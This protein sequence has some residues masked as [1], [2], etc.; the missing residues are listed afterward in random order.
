MNIVFY[1]SV[2]TNDSF[3]GKKPHLTFEKLLEL[4]VE[5]SSCQSIPLTET[6]G[7]IQD[8]NLSGS[9]LSFQTKR[10]QA[11]SLAKHKNV[12]TRKPET[13]IEDFLENFPNKKTN[14]EVDHVLQS[15]FSSDSLDKALYHILLWLEYQ[16]V[17]KKLDTCNLLFKK[18]MSDY[19]EQCFNNIDLSFSILAATNFKNTEL[20]TRKLYLAKFRNALLLKFREDEAKE[21]LQG[22]E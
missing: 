13:I 15:F 12:I 11:S 14:P 8:K 9:S 3:T 10:P 2:S 20:P 18:L 4:N 1:P 22:L 5:D 6:H 19:S 16:L 17:A 21:F 7:K